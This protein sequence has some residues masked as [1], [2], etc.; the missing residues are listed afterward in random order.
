M[1][2]I[3]ASYHCMQYQGK[4]ADQN[5]ENGKKNLVLGLI[6]AHLV[7]IWAA[8]FFF[9]KPGSASNLISWSAI[10]MYNTRKNWWSNLEETYW[11]TDGRTD[12]RTDRQTDG[13]TDKSDFIGRCLTYIERPKIKNYSIVLIF[14][15]MTDNEIKLRLELYICLPKFEK[16]NSVKPAC[17][18][19]R[20]VTPTNMTNMARSN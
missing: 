20:S 18:K 19:R 6:L 8:E 14:N 5:W 3:D 2:C 10:I 4:L 15:F 13:Q 7:Q 12:G 16:Y 17:P 11:R 1:S 9:Q